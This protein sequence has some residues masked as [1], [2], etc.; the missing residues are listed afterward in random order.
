M[1]G[2]ESVFGR[3]AVFTPVKDQTGAE[4]NPRINVREIPEAPAEVAPAPGDAVQSPRR[5]PGR[6]DAVPD[7]LTGDLVSL[8]SAGRQRAAAP[9][10]GAAAPPAVAQPASEQTVSRET[11]SREVVD[12]QVVDRSTSPQ[13][14]STGVGSRLDIVA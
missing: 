10:E 5:V 12:R 1:P 8:S 13:A 4:E 9:Q 11:V 7:A 2:V 6:P 3:N 14:A